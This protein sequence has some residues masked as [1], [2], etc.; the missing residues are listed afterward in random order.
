PGGLFVNADKYAAGE[1]QRFE[2]LRGGLGKMFD[3]LVPL[4]KLELLRQCVLHNVADQA[5]DRVMNE[6]G[7]VAAVLRLGFATVGISYRVKLPTPGLP[8]R[9][10]GRPARRR[11]PGSRPGAV[12]R[13]GLGHRALG[14]G[15]GQGEIPRL[16]V[17]HRAEPARQLLGQ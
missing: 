12:S 8:A 5:P 9:R 2:A 13:G 14:S 4:G 6:D 1:G 15:P 10:A 11:G 16:V 3:V 17:P 7:T